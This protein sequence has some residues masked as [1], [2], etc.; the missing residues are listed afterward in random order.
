MCNNFQDFPIIFRAPLKLIK[1]LNL[2][3]RGQL[4]SISGEI[5]K[6]WQQAVGTEGKKTQQFQMYHGP[7]R[8]PL[9]LPKHKGPTELLTLA[10]K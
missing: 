3:T 5:A 6:Y 2:K 1:R 8:N 7:V 10:A 4:Q 9:V